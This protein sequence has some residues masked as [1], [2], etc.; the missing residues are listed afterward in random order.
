MVVLPLPN[1]NTNPPATPTATPM[2]IPASNLTSQLSAIPT[3]SP[4][5]SHLMAQTA[6]LSSLPSAI[7][8]ALPS[9]SLTHRPSPL[10]YHK[11]FGGL[12]QQLG[13]VQQLHWTICVNMPHSGLFGLL[14]Q[15]E[16]GT[17]CFC[18]STQQNVA[19]WVNN[20]LLRYDLLLKD[21]LQ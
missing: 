4:T 5:K 12:T 2:Q 8:T 9:L 6:S 18:H 19:Q 10:P 14:I 13:W 7:L 20:F 3:G 16:M 17:I 11:S 15:Q 21:Y 1:A